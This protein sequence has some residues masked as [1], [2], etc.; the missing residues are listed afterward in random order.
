MSQHRVFVAFARTLNAVFFLATSAYCLLAFVPFAYQ[1]F[2][3]PEV[4][5]WIPDFLAVH[6]ASYWLTLLL[7]ALTL[8]PHLSLRA[9][10]DVK[11]VVDGDRLDRTAF[12]RWLATG[13]LAVGASVG[14]V[15]A[16]RPVMPTIGNSSRSFAIAL[17]ALVP[18]AWLAVF[19]HVVP[20]PGP[21]E[22]SDERHT[23]LTCVAAA[24]CVWVVYASG[25]WLRLQ[26]IVGID[27][28]L[29]GLVASVG[30]SAVTHL[31]VF[32]AIFLALSA[33]TRIARVVG[34]GGE[35]EYGLLVLLV[36]AAIAGVVH[37]L[38]FASLTFVGVRAAVAAALVGLTI[39]LV[40]S[41]VAR[42]QGTG[43]ERWTAQRLFLSPLGFGQSIA[44]PVLTLVLLPWVAYGLVSATARLDWNFIIQKLGVL[45]IWLVALSAVSALVRRTRLRRGHVMPAVVS[46]GAL[47]LFQ[48]TDMAAAHR[49]LG[50][51]SV[52]DRYA[53]LDAS[54]RLIRDQRFLQSQDTADFYA[55]LKANTLVAPGLV[56]SPR[57]RFA[58]QIVAPKVKPPHIFLFVIDSLRRD[59][60]SPY[61]PAV[62]F[63]PEIARFASDSFVFRRAFTRYSGTGLAVPSIWA[64][65]L[66]MH[67]ID[68]RPFDGRDALLTLLDG[69]GYRPVL[70]IDSVMRDLLPERPDIVELDRGVPSMECDFC[71]T[72][73]ELEDKLTASAGDLR[74]V[75]A[76]T[77]PQNVHI[78]V[79]SRHRVPEGATYQ[80]FF[81]PVADTVR[82]IDRCFGEFI[83][84]LRRTGR[85]DDSVVILTADHGDSLGEEGRWGHSY[86]MVPEV[87]RVPLLVRLPPML[88][89]RV[90]ADLSRVTFTT[91]LAP[92]LY[93]LAGNEPQDLGHL[94]GRPLFVDRAA[95]LP[96]RRRDSFLL[97]SSY[98]AVYGML[99]HDGR[100][101]YA[102][103][104][105]D[106]RDDA[107]DMS[108]AREARRVAI[109]EAML[110][111]NRRL[112]AEQLDELAAMNHYTP[113]G[114]P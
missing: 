12:G 100:K 113:S 80:G 82:E 17:L 88:R 64:G 9:G 48:G 1:V 97:A 57:I 55:R 93:A 109:T 92:T 78:A 31:F 11:V 83:D 67:M 15:L 10:R 60:V 103:D 65:G 62:T 33:T 110:S 20:R 44:A 81:G 52:F 106:G 111:L 68:Q 63:T 90:R 61:N 38:I 102:T 94:F 34:R 18:P 70:G 27:L 22:H 3:K 59:Y 99:R 114:G 98:G 108:D 85:Y 19:D 30:V 107:Y 35:F 101:L 4:L 6:V 41:G 37:Q 79:A 73:R 56:T 42:W 96:A 71:R 105:I 16:A 95:D 54:F 26:H 74:P 29:R 75:F 53:A 86:F 43:M 66:V 58:P 77:L 2:L 104:A 87:M 21:V 32:V 24:T 84:F 49:M 69:V 112:I 7:T 51:D 14:L 72:A 23:L 13:Y 50:S 36:A 40:W 89:G 5:W 45:L 76:Y 47:V 8:K 91:D 39:A 46:V 25:A 28:P